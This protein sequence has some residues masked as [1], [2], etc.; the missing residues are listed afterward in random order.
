MVTKGQ[1]GRA[2]TQSLSVYMLV[3]K[4][5]LGGATMAHQVMEPEAKTEDLNSMARTHV[6]KGKNQLH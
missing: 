6:M 2:R 5:P 3:L 1:C 4:T